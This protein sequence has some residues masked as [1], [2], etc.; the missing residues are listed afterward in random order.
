MKKYT[1]IVEISKSE[2]R[3]MPVCTDRTIVL[4]DHLSS[5]AARY[6]GTAIIS[7]NQNFSREGNVQ[8]CLTSSSGLTM[9]IRAHKCLFRIIPDPVLFNS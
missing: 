2:V 6:H 4:V 9:S 8:T 5:P 7:N 1:Y 3:R